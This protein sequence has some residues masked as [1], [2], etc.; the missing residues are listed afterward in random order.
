M[1]FRDQGLE[2]GGEE[3][4]VGQETGQEL[5]AREAEMNSS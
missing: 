1:N 2:E 4:G 3:A 5:K